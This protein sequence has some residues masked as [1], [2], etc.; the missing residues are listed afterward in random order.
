MEQRRKSAYHEMILSREEFAS[1]NTRIVHY[2]IRRIGQRHPCQLEFGASRGIDILTPQ[3]CY[4][5]TASCFKLKS[6][7]TLEPNSTTFACTNRRVGL[8]VERWTI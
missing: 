4:S 2:E 1:N 6:A 7:I 3:G 5:S 8:F